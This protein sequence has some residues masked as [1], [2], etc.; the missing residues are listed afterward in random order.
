MDSDCLDKKGTFSLKHTHTRKKKQ[1]IK[2]MTFT[3]TE[4]MKEKGK[5][6]GQ[7]HSGRRSIKNRQES[8][9][10]AKLQETSYLLIT[11]TQ[12]VF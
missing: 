8:A 10:I 4:A 12:K 6:T 11:L 2:I 5:Q 9:E 3:K 1:R 7:R